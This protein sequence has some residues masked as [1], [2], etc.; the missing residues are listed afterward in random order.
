MKELNLKDQS[1]DSPSKRRR[2][3]VKAEQ[4]RQ[5]KNS[6][7]SKMSQSKKI[8]EIAE[9]NHKQDDL[10]CGICLEFITCAVTSV[11]GHTFCEICIYEYLLYFVVN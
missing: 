1:M 10:I 4:Q 9:I 2:K 3:I 7:L 8:Q 6:P 11:C 5:K